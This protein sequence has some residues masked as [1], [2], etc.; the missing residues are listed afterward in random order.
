MLSAFSIGS[1]S[2]SSSFGKG[3]IINPLSSIDKNVDT[4][5]RTTNNIS[6]HNTSNVTTFSTGDIIVQGV[7][8]VDGLA[9]AIKTRFPNA[10]IQAMSKTR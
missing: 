3:Y 8:D 10:M 9:H 4:I 5:M 7:Q 6:N 1:M 2:C